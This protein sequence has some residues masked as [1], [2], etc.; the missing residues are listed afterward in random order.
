M[1]AAATIKTTKREKVPVFIASDYLSLP[2]LAFL[3]KPISILICA[4]LF[5]KSALQ[6]AKFFADGQGTKYAVV[7]IIAK[8]FPE[9]LGSR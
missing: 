6:Q 4:R 8:R 3:T 7:E 5:E 2:P 1:V 9:E